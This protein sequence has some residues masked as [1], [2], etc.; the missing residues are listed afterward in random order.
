MKYKNKNFIDVIYINNIL[1]IDNTRKKNY[2]FNNECYII[3]KANINI[4][5]KKI[6]I[7]KIIRY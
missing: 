5:W 3:I 1:I 6:Y 7:L 2:T 4:V